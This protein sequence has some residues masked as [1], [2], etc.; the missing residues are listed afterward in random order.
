MVGA[1]TT[2][3][4][5]LEG[6]AFTPYLNITSLTLVSPD[7][8]PSV[9]TGAADDAAKL[10]GSGG[11]GGG[12]GGQEVGGDGQGE[13]EAGELAGEAAAAT[14]SPVDE[15]VPDAD[16]MARMGLERHVRVVR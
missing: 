16:R 8:I 12:G 14:L 9:T 3:L 15:D 7:G 2:A 13:G 5:C 11:G 4:A 1:S 6:L 10:I